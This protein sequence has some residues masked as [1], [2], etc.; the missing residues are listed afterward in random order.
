MKNWV[1][2]AIYQMAPKGQRNRYDEKSSLV[3][4]DQLDSSSPSRE[5]PE[6]T[7]Y[8]SYVAFQSSGSGSSM[9]ANYASS[10]EV[11]KHKRALAGMSVVCFAL[12][13]TLFQRHQTVRQ[14]ATHE[15]SNMQA[16]GPYKLIE[17]QQGR[18]FFKHYDFYN[19]DDSLGSAGFQEYV[20]PMGSAESLGLVNVTKVNGEDLVFLGSKATNAGMRQSLRLEGKTRFERGLFILD[21]RHMPVGCGVWPAFW[22][23]DESH[24]PD[25]GEIDILE[26]VNYQSHAKTALHTS[27]DCSMYA[28]VP[29]SAYT[30]DWDRAHCIPDTFTG[31]EDCE[32][33]KE[34]DNCWNL[35]PHQWANQG[36]VLVDHRN[37]TIGAPV[38]V[39]GG[40]IYVMEWD[41]SNGYIRSWVFS[42]REITPVNLKQSMDT[43]SEPL[44]QRI[45]PD[46]DTWGLPYA[47][48]KIGKGSG[49]SQDHFS[50]MHIVFNLAFC[51]AVA[52]NRFFSDCPHDLTRQF[53][54]YNDPV[55][56]CN[57][58]IESN[59]DEMTEA[60]WAIRGVYVYERELI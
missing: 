15:S 33:S 7:P 14:V 28:H 29:A 21:V 30:G 10:Q 8:Q 31:L 38:N 39:Q 53:N 27:E 41:P 52:G 13:V 48:F 40:G 17:L 46:P 23:T 11:Y 59:P 55:A 32:T 4:S 19:G 20:G 37:N 42:P 45:V 47:F 51:G 35:A 58:Y 3:S 25:N 18:D 57:A 44:A 1:E 56:S 9:E 26:G 24:W 22:L 2:L 43:S 36:C 16:L 60:Y 50:N 49:C 5:D 34:A 54:F 12:L 6:S